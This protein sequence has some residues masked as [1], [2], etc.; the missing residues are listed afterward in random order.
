MLAQTRNKQV[1]YSRSRTPQTAFK[2]KLE[3]PFHMSEI[4]HLPRQIQLL[5]VRP[6]TRTSNIRDKGKSRANRTVDLLFCERNL[7]CKPLLGL[8]QVGSQQA[9]GYALDPIGPAK[10]VYESS[11]N[12]GVLSKEHG[13]VNTALVFRSKRLRGRPPSRKVAL[14]LLTSINSSIERRGNGKEPCLSDG[15]LSPKSLIEATCLSEQ[16]V[17]TRPN[18]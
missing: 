8:V 14:A 11:N 13:G 5:V 6:T 12:L 9:K 2:L 16:V 7:G 3:K 18:R 17:K 1:P 15:S 10:M 4:P